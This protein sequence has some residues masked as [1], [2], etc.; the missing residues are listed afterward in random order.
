MAISAV[1]PIAGY[2]VKAVQTAYGLSIRRE[3]AFPVGTDV[4]VQ[5]VRPSNLQ[6]IDAWDGWKELSPDAGLQNIIEKLPSRTYT[7]KQVPSDITNLLFIGTQQQI[8]TAFGEAGWFQADELTLRSATKT[9]QATI[10]Q[11]GYASAPVSGLRIDD[12]LPDLVF[13]K[14]LNTF[15]KR[16][17]LRIWKQ[18]G[19]YNG[20]EVWLAAAT[21]DIAISNAK[22]GTKWSHRID[23]HID[24]ERDWVATDLLFVGTASA[25]VEVDRPNVPKKAANATGD[26]LLTDG[27]I[28]IVDLGKSLPVRERLASGF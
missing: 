20:R 25:Y 9:L 8:L 24:R 11:A 28:G 4:Q 6:H 2:T 5:V 1:N 7:A 12:R 23:P 10:R 13:Q 15:A 18:S 19:T 21:H 3:T 16:H 17:H 22:G 14:S 26:Q 27:K